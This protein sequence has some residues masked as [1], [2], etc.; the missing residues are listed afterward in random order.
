MIIQKRQWITYLP[1]HGL[2]P[3][4]KNDHFAFKRATNCGGR[5]VYDLL[6]STTHVARVDQDGCLGVALR[7]PITEDPAVEFLAFVTKNDGD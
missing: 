4:S 3:L 6:Q 1:A 5:M 2:D 7:F